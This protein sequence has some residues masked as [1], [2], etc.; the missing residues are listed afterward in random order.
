MSFFRMF[1]TV[2]LCGRD[3]SFLQ[4]SASDVAV[5][6]KNDSEGGGG[7]GR[8]SRPVRY[9]KERAEESSVS[10]LV[11]VRFERD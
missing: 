1:K 9:L 4:L 2:M 8:L 6:L 3:A 10:R 5:T 7:Y 11:D